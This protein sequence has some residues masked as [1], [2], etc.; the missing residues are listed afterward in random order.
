MT[1]SKQRAVSKWKSIS[2]DINLTE[3]IIRL[4]QDNVYW[5]YIFQYQVLTSAFITEF[6]QKVID[7]D[8]WSVISR[9]QTLDKTFIDTYKANLDWDLVCLYQDLGDSRYRPNYF[10]AIK[11]VTV[12]GDNIFK[13]SKV[14]YGNDLG[15]DLSGITG[16]FTIYGN[17]VSA[18]NKQYT[19]STVT[20]DADFYYFGTATSYT[21]TA[22]DLG[23]LDHDN[24]GTGD[25]FTW[26]EDVSRKLYIHQESD[27]TKPFRKNLIIGQ[28]LPE[29]FI[30]TNSAN[31]DLTLVSQKQPLTE[32]FILRYD[33]RS[34]ITDAT[35]G[36]KFDWSSLTLRQKFLYL[37]EDLHFDS[38]VGVNQTLTYAA[39]GA[40]SGT[41]L[42]DSAARFIDDNVQ[43]G[44]LVT[45]DTDGSTSTIV[46][47]DSQTQ[48]TTTTLT[49]G[50]D[51]TYESSDVV[52][53]TVRPLIN[54]QLLLK[55]QNLPNAF[56][57]K[58]QTDLQ[59]ASV[60]RWNRNLS[61]SDLVTIQTNNP[62]LIE[63][64][65]RSSN[66]KFEY[67]KNDILA[68]L[69]LTD[70]QIDNDE[71]IGY[72]KY[73]RSGSA[74]SDQHVDLTFPKGTT[75]SVL[76]VDLDQDNDHGRVGITVDALPNILKDEHRRSY[77]V[78][79]VKVP[80]VNRDIGT[81]AN[82]SIYLKSKDKIADGDIFGLSD[83]TNYWTF[84][85][86]L[87]STDVST[88]RFDNRIVTGAATANVFTVTGP[89][90]V[91]E[92]S[93]DT[94]DPIRIDADNPAP[95]LTGTTYYVIKVSD[96]KFKVALSVND[97]ISGVAVTITG[98]E[99][100]TFFRYDSRAKILYPH[101][102]LLT[103]QKLGLSGTGIPSTLTGSV[104]VIR[105]N[106][107]TVR[108]ATSRANA[109]RESFIPIT[110]K[111]GSTYLTT[112]SANDGL[113]SVI[114][115]LT[116]D[117][118]QNGSQLGEAYSRLINNLVYLDVDDGTPF[119]AV[120]IY[121]DNK[122]GEST[123]M[124][125]YTTT[126]TASVENNRLTLASDIGID[127]G[128]PITLTTSGGLPSYSSIGDASFSGAGLDDAASSGHYTG[129]TIASTYTVE[130]N[131]TTS[132]TDTATGVDSPIILISS[133]ATF[134]SDGVSAGDRVTNTTD[135]S[136]A[137]VISVNS[138]T[139]LTTTALIGGTDNTYSSGDSITVDQSDVFRWKKD[140]GGWSSDI[141]ITGGT[142]LI[143]EG[144]FVQFDSKYGHTVT[145]LWTIAVG[146]TLIDVTSDDT[147]TYYA[148]KLSPTV[149]ELALTESDALSANTLDII[150]VGTGT[151][152]IYRSTFVLAED[153]N[154][155]TGNAIVFSGS[156]LP[157][158]ISAATTYYA[159]RQSETKFLVASSYANS[160][161]G[162]H[163]NFRSTGNQTN[164]VTANDINIT[165]STGATGIVRS[166]HG[167]ALWVEMIS[168]TFASGQNLDNAPT[169]AAPETT[170]DADPVAISISAV[171]S[172]VSNGLIELTSSLS[173]ADAEDGNENIQ[174]NFNQSDGIIVKHIRGGFPDTIK[175]ELAIGVG[176]V[177]PELDTIRAFSIRIIDN[178]FS[179]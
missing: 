155:Y 161:A 47:I 56:V 31:L 179:L 20:E 93:L 12:P 94:G 65:A 6:I 7:D 78:A 63:S 142:Q 150:N 75:L 168:G 69:E 22:T 148:Y 1:T 51:D 54:Y 165:N 138:E 95:L 32:L 100:P 156:N 130:I 17:D 154:L 107:D 105:V 163:I 123:T 30:V 109:F 118:I 46:S 41:I 121:P 24:T 29:S 91:T 35:K 55:Y 85:H 44:D 122:I 103:G 158:S 34:N 136:T 45:N 117:S 18:N 113:D 174:T 139:Q 40:T 3:T 177:E 19:I 160:I 89:T 106:N 48:I 146:S 171:H 27:I 147:V 8:S 145:D 71:V 149:I 90:L 25:T 39:T 135:G 97:A 129:T 166:I 67:S 126:F 64:T 99:T 176:V 84:I 42:Q 102:R 128:D 140:A 96:T 23:Y 4:N 167:D 79:Q 111:T 119:S 114:V 82:G 131:G 137:E 101:T 144:V 173:T 57:F 38:W 143:D 157:T 9:Y 70:F 14:E 153:I 36:I 80:I 53:I 151:H 152:T 88:I 115:D 77:K 112:D 162:T 26:I 133:G 10:G 5:P 28:V 33:D 74:L 60:G 134:Q 175:D 127:N 66:I 11:A 72:V 76:Q 132:N 124:D 86:K 2:K 159:I 125:D 87:T 141:A 178:D 49:G 13:I 37:L 83:G 21:N 50:T 92:H 110:T 164:T 61:S 73:R 59:L 62:D 68:D 15:I 108:F 116:N 170:A 104:Y 58:H 98:P 120:P 172:S 169:Y 81:L 16:T 43:V 52:Y